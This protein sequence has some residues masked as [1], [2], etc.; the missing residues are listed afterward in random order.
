VRRL[1]ELAATKVRK[2][3]SP[4]S[5]L[6]DIVLT[7]TNQLRYPQLQLRPV[8]TKLVE[9]LSSSIKHLGLLQPILVRP[10]AHETFEVVFGLHRVEACRKLGLKSIPAIVRSLSPEQAFLARVTENLSRNIYVDPISEARG[11]IALI[12]KHYTIGEIAKQI[13]KSDSYVSDR[14]GLIRR[15]HPQIVERIDGSKTLTATHAVLL[16]RVEDLHR[17][18]ELAGL[19]ERKRLSVRSLEELVRNRLPIRINVVS[20]DKSDQV[21]LPSRILQVVDIKPG[22]TLYLH[23]KRKRLVMEAMAS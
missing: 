6:E 9:E 19:V 1:G 12:D 4:C 8:D 14:I 20:S 2:P 13:G 11:Y 3:A 17:Q 16:S 10:V 15:L 22:E 18:L 7:P 5:K 21:A 23:L